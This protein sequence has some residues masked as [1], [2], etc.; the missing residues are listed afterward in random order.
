MQITK[1]ISSFPTNKLVE[2]I[3]LLSLLLKITF[4]RLHVKTLKKQ[5]IIKLG[6]VFSLTSSN[7]SYK[8][9]LTIKLINKMLSRK[10]YSSSSTH[11]YGYFLPLRVKQAVT[12]S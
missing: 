11:S 4:S 12:I 6:L 3:K 8:S 1:A 10:I 2:K 9:N 5:K 7:R